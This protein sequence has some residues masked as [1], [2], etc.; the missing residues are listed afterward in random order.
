MLI[1]NY[2]FINMITIV[3]YLLIEVNK[4]FLLRI[5]INNIKL[6]QIDSHIK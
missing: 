2:K 5:I 4:Y 6:Y 1:I 3:K